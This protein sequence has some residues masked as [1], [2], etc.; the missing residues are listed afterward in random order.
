MESCLSTTFLLVETLFMVL[1]V[2]WSPFQKL[3][4][5]YSQPFSLS[6]V[7]PVL[8]V[9]DGGDVSQAPRNRYI[10][11]LSPRLEVRVL[12]RGADAEVLKFR[13]VV[14]HSTEQKTAHY[15]REENN[16]IGRWIRHEVSFETG[17]IHF[18]D[19]SWLPRRYG[20]EGPSNAQDGD[21]VHGD[22]KT[23]DAGWT[24]CR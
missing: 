24:R 3:L 21:S 12:D 7:L 1:V 8:S 2:L 14:N 19:K 17:L 15:C 13:E 20:R 9:H 18:G 6:D 5:A 10:V 22:A 4:V 16:R 11:L 23:H